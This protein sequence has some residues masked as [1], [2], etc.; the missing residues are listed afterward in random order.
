MWWK[1]GACLVVAFCGVE[2]CD[3]AGV[4]DGEAPVEAE[5]GCVPAGTPTLKAKALD[6]IKDHQV[7]AGKRLR[8]H[9]VQLMLIILV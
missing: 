7:A 6:G 8:S 5:G 1:E 4:D 9:D 3:R 2:V